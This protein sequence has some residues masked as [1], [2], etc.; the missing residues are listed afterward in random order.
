MWNTLAEEKMLDHMPFFW[1]FSHVHFLNSITLRDLMWSLQGIVYKLLFSF[2][3]TSC[4]QRLSLIEWLVVKESPVRRRRGRDRWLNRRKK[5]GIE[6]RRSR[7][8]SGEGRRKQKKKK[9]MMKYKEIGKICGA[10]MNETK[11][12]RRWSRTRRCK[13]RIKRKTRKKEGT[14]S[15]RWW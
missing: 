9:M 12:K 11:R 3:I 6:K 15:I 1:C 10:G 7:R 14:G 4:T 8:R 13:M 5:K 2:L